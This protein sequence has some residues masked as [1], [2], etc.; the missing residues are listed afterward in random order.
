MRWT[1]TEAVVKALEA[2]RARHDWHYRESTGSEVV[3]KCDLCIAAE[4]ALTEMRK[5]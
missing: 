5:A 1:A 3:C 4:A 2:Y